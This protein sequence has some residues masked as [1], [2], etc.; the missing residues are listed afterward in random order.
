MQ[1]LVVCPCSC[2]FLGGRRGGR[3]GEGGKEAVLVCL[4]V[5]VC[6]CDYTRNKL[7]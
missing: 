5:L 2:C 4:F 3:V 6:V 1:I 7:I